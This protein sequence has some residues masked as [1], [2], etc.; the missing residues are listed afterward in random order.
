MTANKPAWTPEPWK[1]ARG[2]RASNFA[3]HTTVVQAGSCTIER[4]KGGVTDN[5]EEAFA[6]AALIAA[7]PSMAAFIL[8]KAQAGD[9]EAQQLWEL[10][11]GFPPKNESG[12]PST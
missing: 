4:I 2:Q 10:A 3:D 5:R 12:G 6:N 7:A 8:K 11:N 9:T 1:A